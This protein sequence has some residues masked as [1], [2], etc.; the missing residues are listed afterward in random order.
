MGNSG[1][2]KT[3]LISCIVGLM[4]FDKGKITVLNENPAKVQKRR[5]GYMPQETALS[6]KLK[7]REM[8]WFFGK[9]FELNKVQISKRFEYLSTLLNLP[10]GGKLI[11]ACRGGEKRRI[12]FAASTFHDPEL[13]ILDEPTVGLDPLLRD[14]IWQY[15]I[16][17]TKTQN[18]TVLLSTH[19][20]DEAKNSTKIGLMRNGQLIAE[21][22]PHTLIE[23]SGSTSLSGA[24]FILSKKHKTENVEF[25]PCKDYAGNCR[26]EAKSYSPPKTHILNALV[27]KLYW[28]FSRNSGYEFSLQVYKLLIPFSFS[29]LFFY[30]QFFQF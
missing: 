6:E 16:E 10:D 19:Y 15:L 27:M 21:D 23:K 29:D 22:S 20:I 28:E 5:I 8:L 25:S 2:G 14:N 9:L 4:T 17:I 24:F 7:I 3:T 12:S 1:C 11:E 30:H 18:K 13:L 26:I